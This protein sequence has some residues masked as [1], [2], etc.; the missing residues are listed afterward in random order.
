AALARKGS[1][2]RVVLLAPLI[3]VV[4]WSSRP[5]AAQGQA[6]APVRSQ[7]ARTSSSPSPPLSG[8]SFIGGVPSGA[9]TNAVVTIGIL[10]AMNRAL[11][12]NLGVLLAE[13]Q[14]GRAAGTRW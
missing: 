8:A 5:A 1:F 12:H 2:V 9:L 13:Q 7:P 14:M 10:D 4:V 11:E 3:V 6:P